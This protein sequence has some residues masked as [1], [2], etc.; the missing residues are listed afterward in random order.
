[1]VLLLFF[2]FS[3]SN[4]SQ[5]RL[6]IINCNFADMF[7]LLLLSD[8]QSLNTIEILV[9]NIFAFVAFEFVDLAVKQALIGKTSNEDQVTQTCYR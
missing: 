9:W 3:H 2:F 5:K 8:F 7:T 4:I 1:M 6:G